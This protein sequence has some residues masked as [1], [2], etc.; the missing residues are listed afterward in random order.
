M[1]VMKVTRVALQQGDFLKTTS[2]VE[3]REP[4]PIVEMPEL[5]APLPGAPWTPLS[6]SDPAV[7]QDCVAGNEKPDLPPPSVFRLLEHNP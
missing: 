5:P 6:V 7:A 1:S 2:P 4:E 3:V